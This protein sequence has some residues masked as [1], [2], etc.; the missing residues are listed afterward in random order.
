L[1]IH[2]S[3]FLNEQKDIAELMKH[4]TAGEAGRIASMADAEMLALIHIFPDNRRFNE[5][6]V[7]QASEEFGGKVI[8]ARDFQTIDV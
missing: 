4:S 7:K 2:D 5:K 6:M 8:V 3:M 1:I